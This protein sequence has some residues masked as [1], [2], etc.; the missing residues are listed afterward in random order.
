MQFGRRAGANR[1]QLPSDKL[2]DAAVAGKQS[3]YKPLGA[4]AAAEH[5]PVVVANAI[6][7]RVNRCP[8]GR[9]R[10][11]DARLFQHL[12]AQGRQQLTQLAALLART[13]YQHETTGK[14]KGMGHG[15]SA[16]HERKRAGSH[17]WNTDETRKHG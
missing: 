10:N 17:G 2:L 9:I 13:S 8:I 1:G 15:T 11:D 7:R 3:V 12:R 16:T 6:K 14:G 4:V 5:D